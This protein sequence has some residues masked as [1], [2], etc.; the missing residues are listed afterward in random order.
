[1]VIFSKVRKNG[2]ETGFEGHFILDVLHLRYLLNF[3]AET[4]SS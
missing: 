4:S 1:M 2:E 3:Q